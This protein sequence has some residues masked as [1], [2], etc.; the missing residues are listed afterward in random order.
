MDVFWQHFLDRADDY[1]GRIIG[2]VVILLVGALALRYL[3]GPLRRF[4]EGGRLEPSVASFLTNSIRGLLLVVVVLAVLQQVGVQTTSLLAVL[5]AAGLAVAISLQNTLANFTAG[6][7]LL[8]FRM[9]RVGD[10]I[11]VTGLRG[12]VTEMYPFHVQLVTEDN[13]V[14]TLPNTLLT[15]G[16]VCNHSVLP[17]RRVQLSVPLGGQLDHAL[18]QEALLNQLRADTCV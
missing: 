16:S 5:A 15:G 13:T 4:L 1:A 18:A 2:V 9:V 14:I 17:V 11:E 7:L 3:L 8:A 12:R 6:L 10:V